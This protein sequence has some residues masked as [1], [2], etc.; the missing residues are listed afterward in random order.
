MLICASFSQSLKASCPIDVTFS[1]ISN[2]TILSQLYKRPILISV[3][4]PGNVIEVIP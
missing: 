2:D 1:G 3:K 4:L